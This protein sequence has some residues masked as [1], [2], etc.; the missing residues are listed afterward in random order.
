MVLRG[1]KVKLV[2]ITKNDTMLIVK[3]RNTESVRKNFI[4][5]EKFTNEMHNYWMDTEVASGRVI[6]YII[7]EIDTEQPIGSVYLR[8]IDYKNKKAE[9]GIFIGEEEKRGN[10]YGRESATLICEYAFTQLGI[11]KIMLRVFADNKRAVDSYLAVGFEKEALLKD[12][13]LQNGGYRNIIL[14]A[15]FWG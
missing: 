7:Y 4:F 15:K 11:H 10:G 13:I 9:F 3:W 8:D 6:Q 12:E 2:P 1:Q 14:M 5:Q